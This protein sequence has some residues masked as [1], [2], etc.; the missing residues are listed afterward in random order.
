MLQASAGNTA[1][2][3][4]S[5]FNTY[6]QAGGAIIDTNGF[7]IQSAGFI[8]SDPGLFGGPDGG[9]I[10]RGAG[11]LGLT[12]NNSY[13]GATTVNAGTLLITGNPIISGSIS[14]SPGATLGTDTMLPAVSIG[15]GG[16]FASG[17]TFS[18]LAQTGTSQP[19]SLTTA[20][21]GILAF[22]LSNSTNNG[23]D[24]IDVAGNL[25]LANSTVINISQLLNNSLAIGTYD[26][27]NAPANSTPIGSLLLT[28][29]PLTRQSY[30][31][32]SSLTEIELNVSTGSAASLVWAGGLNGN[33][34]DLTV[35]KNWHNTGAGNV[36][37][38]FYNLDNVAFTDA[39]AANGA[40][41]LN[42]ALQ[43]GS[44]T[45]TMTSAA[46][47]YS[48]SGT[49]SITGNTGLVMN[50]VG[51]LT[52]NNSN[53]YTGETDIHGGSVVIN[54]G[55]NLGDSS[56][57]NA[58]YIGG[59]AASDSASVA[60]HSGGALSGTSIVLGNAAGSSGAL[61]QNGGTVN[62]TNG[63]LIVGSSGV[64]SVNLTGTGVIKPVNRRGLRD[65]MLGNAA[66]VAS[67]SLTQNG[68]TLNA[69]GG[70]VAG[71]SGSGAVNLSGS[72]VINVTGAGAAFSFGDSATG[73]G[74]LV[75]S[76]SSVISLGTSAQGIGYASIG[77]AGSASYTLN[78]GSF[79]AYTF[80][81]VGDV[82]GGSGTLNVNG[83]T[84][85]DAA[86]R[87]VYRQ[88]GR[89]GHRH[90]DRRHRRPNRRPGQHV[91]RP[92]RRGRRHLQ[93]QR[94]HAHGG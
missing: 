63:S 24:Q 1:F 9:L 33:S 85:H 8:S 17:Y 44:V 23:N 40:V 71:S 67:G 26:L 92:N 73:I 87:Y 22:K 35:T 43:P 54:S 10:K 91:H 25:S 74:S 5:N 31:L 6:V 20:S 42:G 89:D 64:G 78:G 45:L 75:Q 58:T 4:T 65:S 28:G 56:G 82:A 80:L 61:T 69:N 51:S 39:G 72:G 57:L 93:H 83:G 2:S 86:R 59:P 27:I 88:D 84:R 30:S 70:F 53:T 3:P 66:P 34:W 60:V 49:G 47:A 77:R 76:G 81:N 90:A 7:N 29:L 12:G 32:S 38:F 68:G 21:G 41:T 52:V 46:S 62:T 14:V 16:T 94:R 13:N 37:D 18:N 36:P 79:T 11:K 50:G 48:F 19:A 15:A 55:G